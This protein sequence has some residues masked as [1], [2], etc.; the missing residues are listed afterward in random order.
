MRWCTKS[1]KENDKC[2]AMKAP[3]EQLASDYNMSITFSCLQDTSAANCMGK[4]KSGQA[5]LITLDGG[6]INTAGNLNNLFCCSI[7]QNIARQFFCYS[8]YSN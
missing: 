2:N 4:I 8:T 5:D 6:E 3:M 7:A 1:G